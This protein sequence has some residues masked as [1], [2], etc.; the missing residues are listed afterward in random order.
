MVNPVQKAMPK[1]C[2]GRHLV[3]GEVAKKIPMKGR[4]VAIPS[5]MPTARVIQ[6][7]RKSGS[8]QFISAKISDKRNSELK[9][10]TADRSIQPPI[11][12]MLIA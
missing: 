1:K 7:P 3:I 2:S 10:R 9:N 11:E 5:R 4:V 6:R 8:C 12:N